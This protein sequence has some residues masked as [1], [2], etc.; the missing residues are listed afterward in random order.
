VSTEL[1]ANHIDLLDATIDG[2]IVFLDSNPKAMPT[3]MLDLVPDED[4][5]SIR[6]VLIG[7][8]LNELVAAGQ[9]AQGVKL[10]T[11]AFTLTADGKKLADQLA[12]FKA[13]AE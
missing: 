7:E 4:S 13:L 8:A 12:A 10:G 6:L 11:P 2:I 1:T 5:E 9:V 3:D